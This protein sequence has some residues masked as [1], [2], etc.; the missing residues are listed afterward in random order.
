MTRELIYS[1]LK[2]ILRRELNVPGNV[3]S[4]SAELA[5]DLGADSLDIV[6]IVISIEDT[7]HIDIT[8][9]EKDALHTVKDCIDIVERKLA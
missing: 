3:I 2:E 7:F 1:K 4:E 9:E 6:D 5:F 8:N